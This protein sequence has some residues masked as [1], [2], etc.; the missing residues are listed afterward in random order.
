MAFEETV[1]AKHQQVA[2]WVE[3]RADGRPRE[4]QNNALHGLR[5]NG[6]AQLPNASTWQPQSDA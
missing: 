2:K 6:P 4:L 3:G 5:S 1:K